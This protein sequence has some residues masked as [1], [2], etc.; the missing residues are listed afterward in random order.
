M[1]MMKQKNIK[2]L[3]MDGSM[4]ILIMLAQSAFARGGG[5][6]GGRTEG[7]GFSE[8]P[9]I[10]QSSSQ[11]TGVRQNV[12]GT[13]Q[14][15][16]DTREN[17]MGTREHVYSA[18]RTVIEPQIRENSFQPARE[19]RRFIRDSR[20]SSPETRQSRSTFSSDRISR[21]DLGS[22]MNVRDQ[23]DT[24]RRTERGSNN[25]S[26]S[27]IASE[28]RNAGI[29]Q[30]ESAITAREFQ[31]PAENDPI[32][33]NTG[34]NI[35]VFSPDRSSARSGIS[36][37]NETTK[38]DSQF[39]SIGR[40]TTLNH[41]NIGL[42]V[43]NSI[44]PRDTIQRS[45]SWSGTRDNFSHNQIDGH[46]RD[47]HFINAH[48]HEF[49]FHDRDH[50]DFICHRIVT[51]DFFFTASFGFGSWRTSCSIYPYYHRG[52][53]FVNPCGYWPGYTY[54]RY[55]WYGCYPYYWYGYNPIP[56]GYDYSYGGDTY[57]YYT[58]NYGSDSNTASQPSGNYDN[59]QVQVQPPVPKTSA[60]EYFDQGV[61]AFG[62]DDYK[63]AIA[64]FA[65]ATRLSPDDKVLPFAYSQAFLANGDYEA[66][67]IE[68]R[69]ALAKV[70]SVS[71]GV[72]Y[73]RG[74]YS[75]DDV[76]LKQIDTLSEK[77]SQNPQDANLQLLL[78]Y[79]QLGIGELDK[80]AEPL[81]NA[82]LDS[83]NGDAAKALMQLLSKLQSAETT[84]AA[85]ASEPSK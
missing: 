44:S 12:M 31:R 53:L 25:L 66:A 68:L 52:F 29:S 27:S 70:D 67:A 73:P 19:S 15:V 76:L 13:R 11:F 32:R 62:S 64:K 75:S 14:N 81:K 7:G 17:V 55:Y 24:E 83:L 59:S 42:N 23:S 6:R 43:V 35:M 63:T 46:F 71:Q 56:Y 20:I 1:F 10:S 18:P 45:S 80:A 33:T 28:R 2:H 36:H 8:R 74:L 41:E 57:N 26:P 9:Q 38:R 60:D 82:S 40:S 65:D 54:R 51:P 34:G 69:A 21:E 3:L 78:G 61:K 50:D 49:V 5:D 77:A 47:G 30:R 16:M 79:Q 39:K 4:I 58:Y 22:R 48:R 84:A 85:P 37:R 72:F